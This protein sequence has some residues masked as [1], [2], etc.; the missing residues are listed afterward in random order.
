[1]LAELPIITL[2]F[3]DASGSI[4]KMQIRL[5]AGTSAADAQSAA[6]VLIAT[7]T[8]LSD[9]VIVGVDIAYRFWAA[10]REPASGDT[11]EA[12]QGAFTFDCDGIERY[13]EIA[14]PSFKPSLL[15]NAGPG[16]GI[17][18]DTS[19]SDVSAFITTVVDGI[20]CNP[21]ADDI[22]AVSAAYLQW[23]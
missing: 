2:D 20:W 12:H 9:A 22:V 4:G 6:D 10:T 17:L 18:I 15:Q 13:A 11:P 8:A 1:M 21:F 23:R 7:L 16:A 19:N 5:K 14:I 3:L